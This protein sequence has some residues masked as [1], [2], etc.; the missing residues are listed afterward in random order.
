MSLFQAG[1]K[2]IKTNPKLTGFASGCYRLFG[3]NRKKIKGKRNKIVFTGSFVKKSKFLIRGHDN[4]V[5]IEDRSLVK[6]IAIAINGSHN[7]IVIGK[8]CAVYDTDLVIEDDNGKITIGDNSRIFGKCELA[9]IEGTSITIGEGCLISSQTHFRTGDSHSIVDLSGKRINPSMDITLGKH[10]WVG[11]KVTITK[12]GATAENTVIG[13]GAILTK[14]FA[15]GGGVC[16]AGV[17]ARIVKE[18]INWDIHRLPM[19]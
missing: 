8:G 10:T 17:P 2:L 4:L 1:K 19:Q 18:N 7:T 13:T 9:A 12:G 16:L 3:L 6:N 15:S 5:V 11:T 14:S